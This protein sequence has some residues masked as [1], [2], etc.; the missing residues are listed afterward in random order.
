MITCQIVLCKIL[1]VHHDVVDKNLKI[2]VDLLVQH[3]HRKITYNL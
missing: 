1:I 3:N 2:A